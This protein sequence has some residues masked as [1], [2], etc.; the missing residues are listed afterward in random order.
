MRTIEVQK[1]VFVATFL[2]E[3]FVFVERE[4]KKREFHAFPDPYG[5]DDW[6]EWDLESL[7]SY[8]DCFMK[9]VGELWLKEGKLPYHWNKADLR[10]LFSTLS[11]EGIC[12]L[13]RNLANDIDPSVLCSLA[14]EYPEA[15]IWMNPNWE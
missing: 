15:F 9:V 10:L 4:D 8:F 7:Q 13:I 11:R 14:S 1:G 6:Y 3:I 12:A 5:A 2:R